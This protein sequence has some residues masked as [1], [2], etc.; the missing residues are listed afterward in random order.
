MGI[1]KIKIENFK[2]I[3]RLQLKLEENGIICLL[4]K[5]GAG[6]TTVINAI[7]YLYKIA[8]EPYKIEQVIDKKNPYVQ[9]MIIEL[10]FDFSK[11][12]KKTTN[13]YIEENLLEFEK[14]IKNYQLPLKMIQYKNG[15]IEWYPINDVYKVRKLLKIFPLYFIDVRRI[16][17][18][19]WS[20]LW[21]I[22]SDLAISGI[23]QDS[24]YIKNNLTN[25][26]KEIYGEKYTKAINIVEKI[27]QEENITINDREYK[28]RFKNAIISNF[29]GEIFKIKEQYINYYSD[30]MNSLK[31]M[32]VFLKLVINLSKTAWKD[33]TIIFDEP[34]ISLHPQYIEE[35]SDNICEL[36][37]NNAIILSTH[38]NHLVSSLIRNYANIFFFQVYNNNGYAKIKKINDFFEEKDKYLIG[39][40]E[41]SS[42]F[43]DL[44]VL[45]EGQTE[46][47]LFKNK[48]IN[49]LYP[50]LRKVTFYNTK[51]ND[52]VTK[53]MLMNGK[54]TVNFLNIIDMDKILQ[55][56]KNKF[57]FRSGN[58]TV[59]PVRNLNNDKSERYLYYGE[60]KK[61]TYIQKKKIDELV[62]RDIAVEIK[63]VCLR[64][65]NYSS[66]IYNIKKYCKEYNCFPFRTTVEGAIICSRSI[67][68]ILEWLQ[69]NWEQKKYNEF[70]DIIS[71]Y[72]KKIQEVIIRCI[73]HGKVDILEKKIK[74]DKICKIVNQ[75]SK[76]DKV[77][78][79]IFDFFNWYF[80]K[81]MINDI[82]TN[83]E[84]FAYDFPEIND[85]LQ[86]IESML[87]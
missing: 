83:K 8:E 5:N 39:S 63:N 47:Q 20:D 57:I 46:I 70:I 69:I 32:T 58:K 68:I 80:Q 28:K 19:E 26:F 1:S 10:F 74:D 72:N 14:Y 66:L 86:I 54:S 2:T 71:V 76:G 3:S 85:V 52:S 48:R 55:Y 12:Q 27:F 9:K 45:V 21:E 22:V 82:K 42:Y 30:G 13:R 37:C 73:F 40:E 49:D 4:G 11:L 25:L 44:T 16:P 29:G 36:S 59:N 81:Y 31:Y 75:Y 67:N 56:S 15:L 51:S 18:H 87:K 64:G 61:D 62:E 65:N 7:N 79:W 41:S 35:L 43:S 60:R 53:L 24:T 23:E 84:K 78:G 17:L 34:E 77:D 6:K 50:F 38:S 33:I